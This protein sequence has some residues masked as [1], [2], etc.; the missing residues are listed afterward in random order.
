MIR[1]IELT[2]DCRGVEAIDYIEYLKMWPGVA[3]IAL[4]QYISPITR[5][6]PPSLPLELEF[7][8]EG[9]GSIRMI[10]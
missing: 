2:A 10:K 6:E 1:D 3:S 4:L 5:Q 9:E 8:F 7:N